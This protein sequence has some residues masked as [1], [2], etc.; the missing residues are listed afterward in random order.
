M[1]DDKIETSS[2]RE[3]RMYVLRTLEDLKHEERRHSESE[4]VT[5]EYLAEKA[6]RDIRA[7][8]DKIRA[9][10]TKESALRLKNWIMVAA[11][12]GTWALVFE[13]IKAWLGWKP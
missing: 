1:N 12:S 9:L 8:H 13:V 5:R 6:K 7:A 11:L 4:A 3:E 10:E 2:W